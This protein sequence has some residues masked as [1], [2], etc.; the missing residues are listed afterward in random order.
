MSRDLVK[1]ALENISYHYFNS[2][3]NAGVATVAI[4]YVGMSVYAGI[5][6]CSPK[7]K[8]VKYN[9]RCIALRR[10]VANIH[11]GYAVQVKHTEQIDIHKAAKLALTMEQQAYPGWMRGSAQFI[12]RKSK[13]V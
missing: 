10:L 4:G 1:K 12:P 13:T 8:F 6:Y 3:H 2:D 5:A 9:G 11:A 7:D